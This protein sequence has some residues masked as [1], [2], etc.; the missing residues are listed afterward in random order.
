MGKP[1]ANYN[2]AFWVNYP[3]Q[4]LKSVAKPLRDCPKAPETYWENGLSLAGDA[5]AQ[6]R[7]GVL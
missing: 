4:T 3:N 6:D 1:L 2:K 5:I 7:S